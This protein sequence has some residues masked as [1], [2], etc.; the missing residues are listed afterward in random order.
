MGFSSP[1]TLSGD[2]LTY[3]ISGMTGV[4]TQVTIRRVKNGTTLVAAGHAALP[5]GQ[6]GGPSSLATLCPRDGR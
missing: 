5:A 1:F 3:T 6:Q 2:E 4:A